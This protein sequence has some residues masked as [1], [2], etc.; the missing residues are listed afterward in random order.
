MIWFGFPELGWYPVYGEDQTYDDSYYQ[1]FIEYR[2]TEMGKA[3]TQSRVDFVNQH[4]EGRVLDFGVGACDFL[5]S[6]PGDVKG[7][8][9][10]SYPL[11]E[12]HQR[13][14]FYDFWNDDKVDCITCWDSFEHVEDC[15]SILGHVK[16]M[17]FLSIPVFRDQQHAMNSHHFKPHEHWW[18]PSEWG[19]SQAFYECGFDL[20]ATSDAENNL[21]RVGV[22]SY[23]FARF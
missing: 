4:Y 15:W 14:K 9:V 18:Y 7:Y 12:L 19:L 23:A 2:Q 11:R 8:D 22:R 21:G 13:G 1:K 10:A 20:V 17:V 3:I 16:K 6:M 5:D